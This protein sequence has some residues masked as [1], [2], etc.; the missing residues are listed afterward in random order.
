MEHTWRNLKQTIIV[1]MDGIRHCSRPD[2]SYW[3]PWEAQV[4]VNLGLA[5]RLPKTHSIE[6]QAM[7]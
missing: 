4:C 2:E 6:V 1:D 5:F 3:T 7:L